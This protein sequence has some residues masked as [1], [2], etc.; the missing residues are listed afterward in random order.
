M[1]EKRLLVVDDEKVILHLFEKA[2]S[3]IG[4]DVCTATSGE[5]ALEVVRKQKIHVM[6]LDLNMPEMDGLELCRRIKKQLPMSVIYAMTG[7]A[8]LF[9]LAACRDAGFDDYFKKPVNLDLL[10]DA[11]RQGFE[12]IERWKKT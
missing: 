5:A 9:D 12:R 10:K 8:S 6:F 2:F 3:K 7:Y 4:Y 1:S 11:A